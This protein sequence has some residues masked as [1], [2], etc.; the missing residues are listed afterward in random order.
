MAA[1]TTEIL[2]VLAGYDVLP[3]EGAQ[4]AVES[5]DVGRIREGE[6]VYTTSLEMVLRGRSLQDQFGEPE[7][8]DGRLREWRAEVEQIIRRGFSPATRADDDGEPTEPHCRCA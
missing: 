1:T 7:F 3:G 5:P 8:E 6:S 4:P 2:E